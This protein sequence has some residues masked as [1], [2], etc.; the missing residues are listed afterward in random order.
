[1]SCSVQLMRWFVLWLFADFFFRP[2]NLTEAI[3]RIRL[4]TFIASRHSFV[5]G[6]Q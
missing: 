6:C 3:A 2:D 4:K 5:A 1:M